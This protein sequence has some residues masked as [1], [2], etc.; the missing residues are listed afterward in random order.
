M[1]ETPNET[2]KWLKGYLQDDHLEEV[3]EAVRRAELKTSGEIVPMVVKHSSSI[4]HV[5][6]DL[7]IL[8]LL[9]FSLLDMG[10]RIVTVIPVGVAGWVAA[11]L[12]LIVLTRWLSRY[13]AVIRLFITE[14]DQME[15]VERRAQ[16]EFYHNKVNA[17]GN[18]TGVLL[19]LSLLER[20]A[21]V[22]ADQSISAKLPPETWN[23][24]LKTLIEG[25]Q[26]HH[27]G[28]GLTKAI[29]QCAAILEKHFP[30]APG[31][32]NELCN[33]LIIKE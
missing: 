16:L 24:V 5:P 29:D 30:V 6:L 20:K 17:T 3:S 14:H 12:L 26:S 11:I 1:A 25:I 22:L 2:P 7:F 8:G 21:V 4:G 10:L 23:Q 33:R 19:F 13:P 9:I 32:T 28:H 27:V 31:D 18:S 15:M